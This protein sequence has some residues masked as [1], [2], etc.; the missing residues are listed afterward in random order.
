MN[1]ENL[2]L[3]IVG[4][5]LTIFG[6]WFQSLISAKKERAFY[7]RTKRE[8]TYLKISEIFLSLNVEKKFPSNIEPMKILSLIHLYSSK[9]IKNLCTLFFSDDYQKNNNK[10]TEIIKKI[11][12]K[13][14]EELD[15]KE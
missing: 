7:L 11:L 13:M 15:I 9:E 4:S 1:W 2:A 12:E 10:Q 14:R 6:G 8:G 3:L 5:V